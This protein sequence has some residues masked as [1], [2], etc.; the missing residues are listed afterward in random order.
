VTDHASAIELV[1]SAIEVVA[2]DIDAS[3]LPTDADMR[4]EAELDSMDFMAV[5]AE[6]QERGGIE[7]PDSDVARVTTLDGCAGYLVEHG[8][9]PVGAGS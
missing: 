4:V 8:A 3:A 5:L 9:G 2:P 1:R 7:I 6:I